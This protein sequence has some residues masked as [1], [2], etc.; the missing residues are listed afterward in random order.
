MGAQSPEVPTIY[1]QATKI[2]NREPE[3]VPKTYDSEANFRWTSNK[4][5][6]SFRTFEMKTLNIWSSA[7]AKKIIPP[8]K[9]KQTSTCLEIHFCYF[10]CSVVEVSYLKMVSN[11]FNSL[12]N[13][14]AIKIMTFPSALE[15]LG[16]YYM[17]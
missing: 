10:H 14:F 3:W 6:Y 8:I 7:E 11:E 15:M 2:S 9:D 13:T 16:H 17:K 5:S 12:Q 1:P 4:I